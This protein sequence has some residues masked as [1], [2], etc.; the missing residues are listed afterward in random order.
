M[1]RVI[2]VHNCD[3]WHAYWTPP[4]LLKQMCDEL[5]NSVLQVKLLR[6]NTALM[7]VS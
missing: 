1:R 2:Y 5:L 3:G 6:A 4:P 7:R